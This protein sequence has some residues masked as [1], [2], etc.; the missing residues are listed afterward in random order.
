MELFRDESLGWGPL[1]DISMIS[2]ISTDRHC[3]CTSLWDICFH[4]FIFSFIYSSIHPFAHKIVYSKKTLSA[5]FE[6][7]LLN[8]STSVTKL[9]LFKFPSR[10]IPLN[11]FKCYCKTLS[12]KLPFE[13]ILTDF[14][15][16][17]PWCWDLGLE[18]GIWAL[19]MEFG[20][21]R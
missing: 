11:W 21:W 17:E 8:D 6:Q 12:K 13:G 7:L 14:W 20:P 2:L 9:K 18:A 4:L 5:C 15:G 10:C 3:I 16:F 19:K 1:M